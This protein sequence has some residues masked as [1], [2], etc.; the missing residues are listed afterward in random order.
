MQI[1]TLAVHQP[2]FA[3]P[4]GRAILHVH[5]LPELRG[6]GDELRLMTVRSEGQF[7]PVVYE[8][9]DIY[10]G[11]DRRDVVLVHP[12]DLTRLGLAENERVTV[13]S[14]VGKLPG[15]LVRP[16]TD[17]R[18]GNALM[19]FPEANV[20]VSRATDAK[21]KT[22]A[23]KGVLIRLETSPATSPAAD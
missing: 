12:D 9:T 7:N 21:S 17:I 6:T 18:P 5:Q 11:Q 22:P 15:I 16:F 2:K 20:L 8:E 1:R 13:T 19:Y 10:R 14:A 3:T 23:F 4:S